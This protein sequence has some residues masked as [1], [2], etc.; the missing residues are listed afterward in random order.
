MNKFQTPQ[1]WG[2][3]LSVMSWQLP[4]AHKHVYASIKIFLAALLGGWE[5]FQILAHAFWG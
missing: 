1:T 4:Q 3:D 2:R 5:G